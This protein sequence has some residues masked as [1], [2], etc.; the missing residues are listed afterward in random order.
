MAQALQCPSCGSTTR[1]DGL[2]ANGTV[3]C[4]ACGQVMKA[5]PGVGRR[6]AREPT[7]SAPAEPE[8][9]PARE[10]APAVA[11]SSGAMSAGAGGVATPAVAPP[12]PRRRSRPTMTAGAGMGTGSSTPVAGGTVVLAPG[13]RA[14]RAAPTPAP[15]RPGRR[16]S[17]DVVEG[18]DALPL[19]VRVL[20]W[21]VALPLGL[22]IVGVPAR[23]LGYLS[24]QKLLD[25]IVKHNVSR[26]VPIVVIVAL[27]ALV[28]AVLVTVL[29]EGGRRWMLRR[30]RASARTE[31]SPA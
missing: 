7:S 19:W 1:L 2:D 14:P 15:S 11:P 16:G 18:R 20:A 13:D 8:R 21:V 10:P 6:P 23:Q 29:V 3:Q 25:V 24:S 30:R 4:D 12:A 26:F 17:R 28:T 22:L 27:W 5:P 31:R 9:T